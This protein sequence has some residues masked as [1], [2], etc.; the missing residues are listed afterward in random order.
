MKLEIRLEK[1][2]DRSIPIIFFPEHKNNDGTILAY[3]DREGHVSA[4]PTYMKTCKK[5]VS[6]AEYTAC[7]RVLRKWA[8]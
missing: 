1:L 4:S 2:G 6:Q 8:T 5:P 7:M 3:S